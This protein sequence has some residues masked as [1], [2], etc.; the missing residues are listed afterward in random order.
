MTERAG[1]RE[2]S[3][4]VSLAPAAVA[5]LLA[6]HATLFV[7]AHRPE[8]R[9]L[10]GDEGTYLA[11][12][13]RLLAGEPSGLD[14]LWPPLYP[15]FVAGLLALGGGSL[16]L[17]Q[18]AQTALLVLAALLLR[19]VAAS[20]FR[21]GLAADLA[22]VLLLADPSV[23]AFGSCLWPEALHLAL[24]LVAVWIL[25]VRRE[26]ARWLVVLGISLGLALLSKSLLTPFVPLFL[27][28]VG[29]GAPVRLRLLRA[30]LVAIPLG[31]T[32]LPTLLA[33]RR[34]HGVFA[35]A[36]SSRFNV[37][38]GLN[39]R[40]RT[41]FGVDV[42]GPEYRSWVA[43]GATFRERNEVLSARIAERV[44]EEGA[45]RLL[46][47]QLSR[48]YFR[49]FEKD[50]VLTEQLPGGAL[51]AVGAGYRGMPAALATALRSWAYAVHALVL[52][53]AAFGVFLV[54]V[55]GRPAVRFALV[56]LVSCLALFLVLHVKS[57]FRVPMAP[58]LDLYAAAALARAAGA[59]ADGVT[60]LSGAKRALGAA[61]AA[62][63]L[64][65]AFGGPLL[66]R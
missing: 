49:L 12:A 37:W 7:A 13:G 22:G 9:R 17:L 10:T 61:L 14:L 5:A 44:R 50:T 35:I 60:G 28:L 36:D 43:S 64:F 2:A 25:A 40:S 47:S 31:L 39:D 34:E 62:L 52:V 51:H 21:P 41:S 42:A 23:A 57:R 65:F 54:T 20:L 45:L 1:R 30:A 16:A 33:N 66:P 18:L 32:V 11:A 59:D 8:A 63:L 26:E 53:A 46:K 29:S 27:V 38:V 55:R 19:Q 24:L 58:F 56:F 4:G 6:L 48:Q 15:R 3:L